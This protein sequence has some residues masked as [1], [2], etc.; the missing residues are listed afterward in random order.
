MR[1][2]LVCSLHLLLLWPSCRVAEEE[3]PIMA[4]YGKDVTLSCIF[5]STLQISLHRLSI[6]WT[7]EG[8]QGQDLVVH[9]FHLKMNWLVGQ[10]EAYK[11][12]TNL[13]P[14]EFPQGNASLRLSNVRLHD[15]GSYRCNITSEVGS[16]SRKIS[17]AV[18]SDSEMERPIIVQPGEDVILNCSFPPKLNHQSL[19]ITWKKE[20]EA[21]P[22]LLVHSY[23]SQLETQD[24]AYRGR[25]HLYPETFHEGNASL[26][27]GNVHLA[28]EGLYTCYVK[29]QWGR[30]SMRMRVTV[31]QVAELIQGS[32][33]LYGLW[34]MDLVMLL[35]ILGFVLLRMYS[36][37]LRKLW[38]RKKLP[39]SESQQTVLNEY[40]YKKDDK[41]NKHLLQ[42]SLLTS[43]DRGVANPVES[44]PSPSSLGQTATD[45]GEPS[46]AP[47]NP[48]VSKLISIMQQKVLECTTLNIAIVGDLAC[49]KSSFINTMR[50]LRDEDKGAA[51]VEKEETQTEP[52]PYQHPKHPRV[53][54]WRQKL[55]DFQPEENL[56]QV[57]FD[58]DFFI[59]M[60]SEGFTPKHA[61]LAQEMWNSRKTMCYFVRS[62]VDD[63]LNAAKRS[64]P[65]TYN[66]ENILCKIRNDCISQ[67]EE[68]GMKNPKVFLLSAYELD[69]YDFPL[70][71]ETM[72]KELPGDK[73]KALILALP[74]TSPPVLQKKK[75][76]LQKQIWK[77]ALG[78]SLITVIHI[79][80]VST[81]LAVTSLITCMRYY[82]Q[83]FGLD[84]V[85]FGA[86][87]RQFGK[88]EEH[89]KA[90]MK[91]QLAN[92]KPQLAKEINVNVVLQILSSLGCG[93]LIGVNYYLL[94][95]QVLGFVVSGAFVGVRFLVAGGVS[96]ATTYI[97]LK[98]FLN[99]ATEGA[100]RI[101][102]DLHAKFT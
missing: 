38:P 92:M 29:P 35:A 21:G 17:L 19:N 26:W 67:L 39:Q 98:T 51:P 75:E 7:K 69:K 37:S 84:D 9:R 5:P 23:C 25:T 66:E 77:M 64:R 74:N 41:E 42:A 80:V 55:E 11:G 22:D 36:P 16:W 81:V 12:R 2:S 18:L 65:S 93:L 58:P 20:Q 90:V 3:S 73:K 83:V 14:Q 78:S 76:A 56:Q 85:S 101:L 71:R 10:E 4:Q 86:L 100:Q 61:E 82:C 44:P 87:A 62:K 94:P 27:L 99:N 97:M 63:D 50:G 43:L 24:E 8:S 91:P 88:P 53:T 28:D 15:E 46:A 33:T 32:P 79:P 40:D 96:L 48:I 72:E 54:F 70:L 30:F 6:I 57:K 13:Y 60:A 49:G 89:L 52:I 102:K 59:I 31:E 95:L 47:G 1:V 34:W 45:T 68:G